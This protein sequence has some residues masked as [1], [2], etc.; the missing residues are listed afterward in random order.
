MLW[1]FCAVGLTGCR[2][3]PTAVAGN[4]DNAQTLLTNAK[5]QLLEDGDLG[6]YQDAVEEASALVTQA[7]EQLGE[8]AES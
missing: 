7:R 6:A 2:E 3:K 8:S 1:L 5:T 4:S